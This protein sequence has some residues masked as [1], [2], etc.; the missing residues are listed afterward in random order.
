MATNLSNHSHAW[1]N[2]VAVST[3]GTT[4]AS[5]ASSNSIVWYD[6]ESNALKIRDQEPADYIY[7]DGVEEIKVGETIKALTH[8]IEVLVDHI[9]DPELK[10]ELGIDRVIEQQKMM[11]KLSK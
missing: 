10:K 11:R 7:N 3:A 1:S 2:I 8:I 5:D 9:D 6:T 4:I